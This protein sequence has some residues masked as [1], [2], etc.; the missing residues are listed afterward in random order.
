MAEYLGVDCTGNE[1]LTDAVALACIVPLPEGWTQHLDPSTGQLYWHNLAGRSST[2]EHPDEDA[3]CELLP[4]AEAVLDDCPAAR[5]MA[6]SLCHSSG[7]DQSRAAAAAEAPAPQ[8]G[9]RGAWRNAQ[10]ARRCCSC[11]G[12]RAA[13]WSAC[14]SSAAEAEAAASTGHRPPPTPAAGMEEEAAA[15]AGAAAAASPPEASAATA[16]AQDDRLSASPGSPPAIQRQ[17]ASAGCV[18]PP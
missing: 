17:S 13:R 14:T 6:E 1:E 4:S 8:L 7:S 15:A 3:L 5:A 9:T 12:A 2:W 18:A 11:H 10:L 16:T